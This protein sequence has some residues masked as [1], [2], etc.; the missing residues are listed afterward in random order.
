MELQLVVIGFIL[1]ILLI[2][3]LIEIKTRFDIR[4]KVR[5]QWGSLPHGRFGDKEE[6]LKN[7]W[8]KAKEYRHYDSEVDDIT[9]YDLDLFEVYHSLN[10]TYSSAGSEALYQRLR[11]YDFSTEQH[12]RLETLID[13]YQQNP[14]LREKLQFQFAYLGKKDN[15]HVESYLTETRKQELP[16][17]KL[18]TFLGSLPLIALGLFLVWPTSA[19]IILLLGSVLFNV[20]YYLIKK[21]K[22]QRELICMG[23]L[24]QTVACAKKI[25]AI[26]TPFQAELVEILKPLK[27]MPRFGVSFRMKSNTEAELLFDYISMVFMLPF[28]SYN[29]VL[30][31]LAKYETQAKALWQLLGE[32]EVAA[33][34]LNFR[35]IMP[36]TSQPVFSE[37]IAV[38][39]EE[40]YHPLLT[41]PVPNEVNWRQNTLVTG[42]NASGKSTYV[43]SVAISC[44]LSATIHTALATEFQLP[45]GHILTSMAVEDDL[46]EGDSYFVAETKSVKRVLDLAQTNVPCLCFIDEILKGTNTIERIAASASIVHWLNDYPSLA[47]VATHDIELTE[48]LKNSCANVHFEE[49]VTEE[50]GVTFDYCLR[51]GPS[52]TRN[53]IQL[54]KVLNYPQQVVNNAQNEATYFD[55]HRTWQIFSD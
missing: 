9:W 53:A 10:A 6:S 29:F 20:I 42:S 45:Y 49:Q 46:F 8:L 23:Y 48:I 39:G 19:F 33:A 17:M 1:L 15:N 43:K 12:Q 47:F 52:T 5:R 18:Y 26:P 35:L 38:K 30:E 50:K 28:I 11:N 40:V 36:D 44:I 32:L 2:I 41:T 24:V 16:H 34:V 22:L 25:A 37:E 54:L 4:K 21:E 51:Q 14:E 13:F 3:L 31:K 55:Q 7:A 27:S